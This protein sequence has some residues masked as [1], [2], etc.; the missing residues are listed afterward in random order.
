MEFHSESP[1][2]DW[3]F[4]RHPGCQ[5]CRLF[6]S[7]TIKILSRSM[8]TNRPDAGCHFQSLMHGILGNTKSI[9]YS[10]KH[11]LHPIC[12]KIAMQAI[13]NNKIC[14]KHDVSLLPHNFSWEHCDV[15]G[16]LMTKRV[17][18]NKW[19]SEMFSQT[20]SYFLLI[21]KKHWKQVYCIQELILCLVL[22]IHQNLILLCRNCD[23]CT[24]K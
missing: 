13:D 2:L 18:N 10:A 17:L 7:W 12:P 16:S 15:Y 4:C 3:C 6:P 19:N 21:T 14:N 24:M 23:S 1:R 8:H 22:L 20:V 11:A 9:S 5:V